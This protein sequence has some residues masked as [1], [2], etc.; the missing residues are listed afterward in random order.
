MPVQHSDTG[1]VAAHEYGH[2]LGNQD[3]Y[4]D[5]NCPGRS[6]VNKGIVMDN[7]SDIVPARLVQRFADNVRSNVVGI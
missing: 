3:E 1:A 6:P 5:G 7:N 2:M 4:T